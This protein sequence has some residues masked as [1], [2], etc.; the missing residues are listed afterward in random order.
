M[1]DLGAPAPDF[2]LPDTRAGA[3]KAPVRRSS[4]AERPLL[5]MFL[6]N[7]CPFVK[8]LRD[9]LAATANSYQT[10]GIAVVAISSND[11]KG[12]PADGPEKM[13]AEAAA[14]GYGFPYLYD[15]SQEVA[16]AY[17]AACTP[18]FFLYDRS[19]KLVYRGQYDDSRPDNGVP[20]TGNDLK[21]A[22]DA[23]LAGKPVPAAQKASLGCNIKWIPGNEPDHFKS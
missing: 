22:M 21:A 2:A 3:G 17:R 13:A 15:A 11:V 1:V 19:H 20:V 9:H 10:K 14:G 12:Y 4:F 16:K 23:V 8:H 18:D 5:V 6:A 7:H